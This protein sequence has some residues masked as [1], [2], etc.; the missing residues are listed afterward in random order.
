MTILQLIQVKENLNHVLIIQD[1]VA[2]IVKAITISFHPSEERSRYS[3]LKIGNFWFL[4][5]SVTQEEFHY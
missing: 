2:L 5:Q 3:C 4:F 1:T